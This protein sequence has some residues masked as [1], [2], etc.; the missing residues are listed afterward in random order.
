M[1]KFNVSADYPYLISDMKAD[2]SFWMDQTTRFELKQIPTE[3]G[4]PEWPVV[5]L[6]EEDRDAGGVWPVKVVKEGKYRIRPAAGEQ[7][8]IQLGGEKK[9]VPARFDLK[10]EEIKFS[11]NFAGGLI[12]EPVDSREQ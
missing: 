10:A 3:V 9:S 5:T 4:H 2:F 6:R 11:G 7:G 1:E 8:T 12:I